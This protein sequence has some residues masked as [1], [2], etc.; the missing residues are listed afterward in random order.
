MLNKNQIQVM[1]K[2]NHMFEELINTKLTE[3]TRDATDKEISKLNSTMKHVLK[4]PN[5]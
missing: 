2:K 3:M 4:I 5:K 1:M